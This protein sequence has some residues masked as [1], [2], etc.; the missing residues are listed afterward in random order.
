MHH[1]VNGQIT[2]SEVKVVFSE[3]SVIAVMP[4][5]QAIDL[6]RSEGMDLVEISPKEQPPVCKIMNYGKYKYNLDK[7]KKPSKKHNET[8]EMQFTPGIGVEDYDVKIKKVKEFLTDELKV[9]I[10][11][12][13]RGR[14][15]MHSEI[16]ASL[17]TKIKT[18]CASLITANC[19]SSKPTSGESTSAKITFT[20]LPK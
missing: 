9:L 5:R 1:K 15:K 6:A 13:M 12:K 20:L 2:A 11:I 8:K 10:V 17:L 7:A 4:L 14:E 16:S 18:D 3:K 19:L